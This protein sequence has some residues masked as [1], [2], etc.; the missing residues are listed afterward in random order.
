MIQ[1][2]LRSRI[3]SRLVPGFRMSVSF[4]EVQVTP[5]S[6]EELSIARLG[7]GPLSRRYATKVP[8]FLRTTEGC[9]PPAPTM[10]SLPVQVY[11][12]SSLIP[13]DIVKPLPHRAH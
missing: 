10:G 3:T 13:G 9:T 1:W 11:P 4:A 7:G 8:S 12:P 6:R 2:P 5:S